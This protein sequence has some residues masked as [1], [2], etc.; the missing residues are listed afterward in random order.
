MEEPNY[1]KLDSNID[2]TF[3]DSDKKINIIKDMIQV[4]GAADGP[5]VYP[6]NTV[7]GSSFYPQEIEKLKSYLDITINV[8][9]K[10]HGILY[11]ENGNPYANVGDLVFRD[12]LNNKTPLSKMFFNLNS[13]NRYKQ[14]TYLRDKTLQK[15]NKDE[16]G[17]LLDNIINKAISNTVTYNPGN[18]VQASRNKEINKN[19][20]SVHTISLSASNVVWI[21]GTVIV[22]ENVTVI[23]KNISMDEILA[24]YTVKPQKNNMVP[25]FISWVGVLPLNSSVLSSDD[26]S[27]PAIWNSFAKKFFRLNDDNNTNTVINSHEIA[28]QIIN[29]TEGK[30]IQASINMLCV[31]N[32]NDSKYDIQEGNFL[33]EDSK[34]ALIV[35]PT[36]V[37]SY[38]YTVS[39]QTS[40]FVQAWYSDKRI[41]GFTINFGNNYSGK[42]YWRIIIPRVNSSYKS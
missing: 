31:D 1:F 36:E 26:C 37:A 13:V 16:K 39:L 27:N 7:V 4:V 34:E 14:H 11:D 33:V 10:G 35:F 12:G 41:T 21:T 25:V 24:T 42:V 32:F 2:G 19:S 18:I 15:Y 29:P 30:F 38:D 6:A 8:N 28:I 20:V 22:S 17:L 9:N 5:S 23:L 40:K 3:I